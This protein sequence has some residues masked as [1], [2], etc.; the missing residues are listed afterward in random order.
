MPIL[1]RGEA[2]G[3]LY[4]TEKPGGEFTDDDEQ[5][6]IDRRRLGRRRDRQRPPARRGPRRR[7]ELERTVSAMSATVEI[8]RVLAGETDLDVVLQLIAKRGRALVGA[9]ALVIQLAH[10][11]RIRVAAVAGDVDRALIGIELPTDETVAGRVLATR[12][13]QRLGDEL[14][15]A[16]FEQSGLGRSA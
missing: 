14:N 7:D 1:V 8:S 2:W 13:S 3:N 16:R 4:L 10:G 15:R 11:D 6:V 9:R 5:A 12:R